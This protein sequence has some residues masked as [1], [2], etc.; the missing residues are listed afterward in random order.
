MSARLALGVAMALALTGCGREAMAQLHGGHAPHAPAAAPQASGPSDKS[1]T[2][3]LQ[4]GAVEWAADPHM[5]AFYDLTVATFANGPDKVDAEA[6]A[7]KARAIFNEFALS[8]G[9]DPAAMQDHLK[10]IPQQMLQIA[11]EDP[12]TLDSYDNFRV[13]LFGPD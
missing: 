13:A 1:V 10:A 7:A 11:K 3:T 4:P 5:H 6:Y 12:K 9:M 2:M 8:H